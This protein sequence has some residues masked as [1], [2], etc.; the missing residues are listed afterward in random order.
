M[1]TN[2]A[3]MTSLTDV[4]YGPLINGATTVLF[5]SIPT[6]PDAGRYWEVSNVIVER[7][8]TS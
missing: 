8:V 4:V 2:C 5:E 6:F 1:V 3:T 7:L